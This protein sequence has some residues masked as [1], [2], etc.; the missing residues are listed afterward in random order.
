MEPLILS[1]VLLVLGVCILYFVIKNAVIAA[2][3]E[4]YSEL[5]LYLKSMVKAGV[6]EALSETEEKETEGKK[7]NE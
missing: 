6:K 5:A 2:L 3:K 4:A 7:E 1:I